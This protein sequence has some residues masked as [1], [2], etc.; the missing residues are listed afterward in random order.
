MEV[1]LT[2]ACLRVKTRK[3]SIY[4]YGPTDPEIV[5]IYIRYIT[6]TRTYDKCP[7]A[8]VHYL[9]FKPYSTIENLIDEFFQTQIIYR[10]LSGV[11]A[12]HEWISFMDGETLDCNGRQRVVDI[13]YQFALWYFK[14][15]FQVIFAIHT[16]T[17]Y[18]HIHYVINTVNFITGRKYHSNQNVLGVEWAYLNDIVK[19]VTGRRN[20]VDL[21]DYVD[22]YNGIINEDDLLN[23]QKYMPLV[24]FGYVGRPEII[25]Q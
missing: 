2:M 25:Y 12:R 7:P 1:L 17:K 22:C 14:Q 11:R 21:A 15:G 24:Q 16:D 4:E 23:T 13:A 20:T 10:Q 18:L 3:N 9:G 6:R 5:E 8:Y 19:A